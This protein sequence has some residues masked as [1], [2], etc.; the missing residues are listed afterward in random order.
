MKVG[1]YLSLK[2][3]VR[4]KRQMKNWILGSILESDTLILPLLE[5]LFTLFS[6]FLPIVFF[7]FWKT[8]LR[9]QQKSLGL[10]N[11]K[12]FQQNHLRMMYVN[13]MSFIVL[14]SSSC[15][16]H[17]SMILGFTVLH[18]CVSFTVFVLV[19]QDIGWAMS[20][21]REQITEWKDNMIFSEKRSLY[22]FVIFAKPKSEWRLWEWKRLK[23]K[24]RWYF[25]RETNESIFER[26]YMTPSSWAVQKVF[27]L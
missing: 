15:D 27:S 2:L 6:S 10:K 8:S 22:S 12:N 1:R 14:P 3:I 23:S 4:R 19:I 11:C 7:C 24:E 21:W 16:L 17:D 18:S 5:E 25:C 13:D 26:K 20:C 9:A